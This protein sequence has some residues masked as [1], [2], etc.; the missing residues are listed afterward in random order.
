MYSGG[1]PF[2]PVSNDGIHLLIS[3][4]LHCYWLMGTAADQNSLAPSQETY[5][6]ILA[7]YQLCR[8]TQSVWSYKQEQLFQIICESRTSLMNEKQE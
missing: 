3:I 2:I 7:H 1:P 6:L 8:G 4:D 5:F